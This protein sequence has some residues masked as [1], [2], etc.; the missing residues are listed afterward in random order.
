[1]LQ[2]LFFLSGDRRWRTLRDSLEP[3]FG[4][5]GARHMFFLL[6]EMAQRLLKVLEAPAERLLELDVYDQMHRFVID[7]VGTCAFGVEFESMLNYDCFFVRKTRRMAT[8]SLLRRIRKTL[9][10]A[11]PDAA[12]AMGV[13]FLRSGDAD[14]FRWLTAEIVAHRRR[15]N[16]R[17]NDLMQLLMALAAKEDAGDS[18]QSDFGGDM[19]ASQVMMLLMLGRHKVA[20][21]LAFCLHQLAVHHEVQTRARLQVDTALRKHGKELSL[22]ALADMPYLDMVLS[23]TLRLHP[24]MSNLSRS[25]TAAYTFP[26]TTRLG[27]GALHLRPGEAPLHIPIC[28]LHRDPGYFPQPERFDPERFGPDQLACHTP[29][30]YLP[31]GAGQRSCLGERLALLLMKTTLARLLSRYEL[32]QSPR[33]EYPAPID[34]RLLLLHPKGGLWVRISNRHWLPCVG[35]NMQLLLVPLIVEL[36]SQLQD[37]LLSTLRLMSAGAAPQRWPADQNLQLAD[38][39]L[40][41]PEAYLVFPLIERE[42]K[43]KKP[44]HTSEKENPPCHRCPLSMPAACWPLC[45]V[46]WGTAA[47]LALAL[48]LLVADAH[49]V[50]GYWRRMG[51][52][53]ATSRLFLGHAK[54]LLL[55]TTHLCGVMDEVYRQLEGQPYGGFYMVGRPCLMLRDPDLVWRVKHDSSHYSLRGARIK[56]NA[57]DPIWRNLLDVDDR[58][59]RE[60]MGHLTKAFVTEKTRKVSFLL[61][62]CGLRMQNALSQRI[63]DV[64]WRDFDLMCVCSRFATDAIGCC[65]F[66]IECG[67]IDDPRSTFLQLS[68]EAVFINRWQNFAD[69]MSL[70]QPHI[71]SVL[72]PDILSRDT[73][74]FFR[75]V[76]LDI[77]RYRRDNKLCRD[78]MMNELL[79][80]R[81]NGL[82]SVQNSNTEFSDDS[83]VAYVFATFGFALEMLA[84]TL[85]FCLYELSLDTEVQTR[86]RRQVDAALRARGGRLS[87]EAVQE[88]TY[89]DMVLTETLRLYPVVAGAYLEECTQTHRLSGP[90]GSSVVVEAGTHVVAPLF[91]LQRDPRHF[92]EPLRFIPERWSPEN[93]AG[94]HPG[95]YMPYG[96]GQRRCV[97]EIF[98]KTTMKFGLASL[99]AQFEL[100]RCSRTPERPARAH[101]LARLL[102]PA[103]PLHVR[104]SR[105]SWFTYDE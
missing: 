2:D 97:A 103:E 1:M 89:L 81:L 61:E 19:L 96:A 51:V 67:A 79:K 57:M 83:L 49:V 21:T 42:L 7:T 34:P 18:P 39:R 105:R 3:G 56:G 52:A 4:P 75:D 31:F 44:S 64:G 6:D 60:V 85:S 35:T 13:R 47:L 30:S 22:E 59:W 63:E 54:D 43:E 58:H 72:R 46:S 102:V 82:K 53:Q 38:L 68:H 86:A 11:V 17:R 33:T 62:E 84:S 29:F 93:S 20:T 78:D 92:P 95:V 87:F 90:G 94:R 32:F 10:L 16:V 55:G 28:A 36:M 69:I 71:V 99:L 23:E 41:G 37:Q 66:G 5:K 45:D 26:G 48:S 73:Y 101:P 100:S 104:V 8:G 70:W 74:E 25:C 12:R 15:H 76:A 40:R 14:V 98:S 24:P 65:A 77:L 88:M 27:D 91:S 50:R 9:V 80:V